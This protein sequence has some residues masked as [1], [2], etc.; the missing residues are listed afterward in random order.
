MPNAIRI[1]LKILAGVIVVA[2]LVLCYTVYS[3][4]VPM[5]TIRI[6]TGKAGVFSIGETKENILSRL[7][8]ETF[9]PQ[10]KPTECPINW[11]EVSKMTGTQRRCL[12]AT[13]IWTEGISS[14]SSL[15]PENVDV[16]ANLQFKEGK[17]V[18]V[19]TECWRPQ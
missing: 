9:S 17:L 8:N 13:N 7:P 3:Y 18:E 2:T 1:V 5:K 6:T 10:P 14:T 16:Y 15:C 4:S 12:L 19:T 11:I